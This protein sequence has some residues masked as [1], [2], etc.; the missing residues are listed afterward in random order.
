M[1][2]ITYLEEAIYLEYLPE[3]VEAWKAARVLVS[4][5]AAASIHLESGIASLVLPLDIPCL[6]EL[7]Q[8]EARELIEVIPC[9]EEYIEIALS[10]IW[11]AQSPESE[12]GVFV[13][14]LDP[15]SEYFLYQLWQESQISASVISE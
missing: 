9:D 10:G 1:L 15:S 2:K 13:C 14:E 6:N 12:E 5:R 3:S 8:L 7:A 4:L 11:V